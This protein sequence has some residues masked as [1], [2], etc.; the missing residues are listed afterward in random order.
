MFDFKHR[1][2]SGKDYVVEKEDKAYKEEIVARVH[3]QGKRSARQRF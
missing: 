2:K 3:M 1:T